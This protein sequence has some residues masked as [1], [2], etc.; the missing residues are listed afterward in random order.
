MLWLRLT[1]DGHEDVAGRGVDGSQGDAG[2]RL[3]PAW[4]MPLHWVEILAVGLAGV[5]MHA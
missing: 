5:A 4:L 3:V 2:D 1:W